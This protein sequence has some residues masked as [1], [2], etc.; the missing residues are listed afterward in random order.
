MVKFLH[1]IQILPPGVRI[2]SCLP[3]SVCENKKLFFMNQGIP[4]EGGS[5]ETKEKPEANYPAP[6]V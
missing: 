1:L 6:A 2:L 3:V 4:F 5:R